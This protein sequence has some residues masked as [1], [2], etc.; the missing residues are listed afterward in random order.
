MDRIPL[1]LPLKS[2]LIGTDP[3]EAAEILE[4]ATPV[5]TDPMYDDV[6]VIDPHIRAE[7]GRVVVAIYRSMK[8]DRMINSISIPDSPPKGNTARF[9]SNHHAAAALIFICTHP[10]QAIKSE[11][12]LALGLMSS[13]KEG[14]ANIWFVLHKRGI[15]VIGF[16]K[17]KDGLFRKFTEE[18]EKE[19][20]SA[21]GPLYHMTK[22]DRGNALSFVG[23]LIA[24]FVSR[25]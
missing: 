13:T 17:G 1:E 7:I 19:E 14:A 22:A 24:H 5:G 8:R 11:A 25:P 6:K 9:D 20:K 18:E 23:N 2:P 16:L 10:D 3:E 4:N 21:S 15:G 12:Y